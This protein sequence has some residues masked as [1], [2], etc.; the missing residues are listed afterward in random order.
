[1]LPSYVLELHAYFA[2]H[3]ESL[4][5]LGGAEDA[6][7]DSTAALKDREEDDKAKAKAEKVIDSV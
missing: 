1:M 6:G 2:I 3:S 7:V 4:Y 5:F